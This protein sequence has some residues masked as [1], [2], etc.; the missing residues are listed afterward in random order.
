MTFKSMNLGAEPKK[1]AILAGLAVVLVVVFLMNR[2]NDLP[3]DA[4]RTPARPALQQQPPVPMPSP[5][6]S[7]R[8]SVRGVPRSIAGRNTLEEF[9][10]SLKPDDA[11]PLDLNKVEPTLKLDLLAKLQNVPIE[12]GSRSLFDFGQAPVVKPNIPSVKPIKPGPLNVAGAPAGGAKA[13]PPKP[14]PPPI[15]LKFYGYVAPTRQAVKRG[16]F[17]DGDDIFV[18]GEG[19]LIKNRYRVVRIGVNSVVME[20][21][22]NKNRQTLPL[23]EEL[24]G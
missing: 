3:P 8:A 19:D 22:S 21:T 14:P 7:P 13:D 4:R 24:A 9:H 11:Q 12:G 20:D 15:P 6:T 16:F 10:P 1:V 2:G 18:A 17:L 5:P 23:V